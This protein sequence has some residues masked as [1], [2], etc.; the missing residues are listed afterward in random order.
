[1]SQFNINTDAAVALTNKLEK[2]HR[3]GLPVAIRNTLNSAAFDVKKIT[4]LMEASQVF[5]Q[6]NKSFFK[7]KSKVMMAK[8]FNMK[9]MKATV[10]FVGANKNQAVDDLEKQERGGEIGGRSFIPMDTSRVSKSKSKQVK[11][12]NRVGNIRNIDRVKSQKLFIKQ[13]VKT[14]VGG[15]ILYKGTVFRVVKISR[16]DVK[17]LPLFNYEKGR[18]VKVEAT[19]FM[20]R[21]SLKSASSMERFYQGHAKKQIKRLMK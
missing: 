15:H 8:G 19:H 1:V 12:P 10:G 18:A 7:S 4:M 3:S 16:G 20:K 5:T 2:L 17:L 11:K 6:R 9:S 21:A 14:G 13:V